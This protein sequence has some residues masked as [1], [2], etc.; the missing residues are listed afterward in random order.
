[1][2]TITSPA[3]MTGAGMFLGTAAYMSPEQAR[4]KTV[5]KRTDIW[6]FGAVLF[7]MLTGRRAFAGE[8]ITDTIVSVISKEPDWPA[9]PPLTPAAVR[10][11]L[12]RCL[13]KDPKRRLRDIGEARLALEG[14]FEAAVPGTTAPQT[15]ATATSSTPRG[16]L[17]WMAAFVVAMVVIIALAIP[18]VRDLREA[19]P[20]ETR[21]DIVTP[22]TSDPISFALSPDGRQIVFVASGDGAS[23]FWLRPLASTTA[24]PLA[25]TEGAAYPFWSPDSRSVGFFAGGAL[26]RLDMGGGAPQTLTAASPGRGGTWNANGVILFAPNTTSPLFRIAAS[27]GQAAAVTKLDQQP[28]HRHPFFLPDGRQFL[29]Y[30]TGTA[31]AS[32]I[33]LGSLDSGD[34]KRLTAADTRGVYLSSGWLLWVRA[35]ALVAQRLERKAL[36]G[37]PITLADPVVT[38]IASAGAL[39][40]SAAGLVAYRGGGAGLWQLTWF[41]RAGKAVGVAGE[42]DA[43][44]VNAPELSPDGRRVAVDRTVQGNRDVWLMDLVREGITRFTFDAAVDGFPIW[45]P[46]GSRI[47]FESKRKGGSF[48][49]WLKPSS[50]AGTEELLLE[51]PNDEWP[52]DWSKDD[53]FLLYHLTDP[54]TGPDLWSLPMTGNDRKPAVVVNTPFAE[55]GGQFA[56]DGRWVAYETN[57]SGRLEIVV[58]PFPEPSGKWQLSTGG[59]RHPR[60]RADGKELY[61]I[62]PDGTLMAV[63]VAASGSTFEAGKPV[64][65]FPM[66]ASLSLDMSEYAVSRDGRFLINQTIEVSTAVSITLIQ[67]WNPAAAK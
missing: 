54:K 46:D 28:S 36:T 65:L 10:S 25:G 19:P 2:P 48:D 20:P 26:K 5:D 32:G 21:V 11:L 18:A 38:D 49:I 51:T 37:D 60:W 15:I 27:G 40:V 52:Y 57:E 59:G 31:D 30:A 7:E 58:Q 6:A 23:H 56:P 12:R 55:Q 9:L 42:P 61:F 41:D 4:G 53:R 13:D 45:S 22:A 39:S 17:I 29:F 63:T 16:R 3:M 44:S 14:A 8:D 33:Y 43:N 64:A 62:A 34:T 35:Q 1:M 50:G 66:S 24:Q 47:A 67:N